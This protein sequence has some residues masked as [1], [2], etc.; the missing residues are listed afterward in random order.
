MPLRLTS[1]SFKGFEFPAQDMDTLAPIHTPKRVC[2][3]II[4]FLIFCKGL[5]LFFLLIFFRGSLIL[6]SAILRK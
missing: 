2:I 4:I 5:I 6:Q 1:I 3:I